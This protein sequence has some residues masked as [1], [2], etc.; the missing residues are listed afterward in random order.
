M[1]MSVFSNLSF[2]LFEYK[3]CFVDFNALFCFLL[4][5]PGC[6]SIGAGAFI[7]H[8]PFK[9]NGVTLTKNEYSWNKGLPLP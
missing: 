7:E 1:C 9:P 6:S 2:S 5:G 4:Q 8:G 3:D